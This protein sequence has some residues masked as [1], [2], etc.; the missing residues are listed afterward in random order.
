[1]KASPAGDHVPNATISWPNATQNIGAAAGITLGPVAC[2]GARI[3]NSACHAT[4]RAVPPINATGAGPVL[5]A[6]V[7]ADDTVAVL[8]SNPS[9]AVLVA[10]GAAINVDVQCLPL[11]P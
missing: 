5:T 1:M 6:Y 10:T 7:P 2:V 3:A 9:A 4:V 8:V 11:L